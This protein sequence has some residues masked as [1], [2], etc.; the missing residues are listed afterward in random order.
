MDNEKAQQEK[1]ADLDI[2]YT[3]QFSGNVGE[4]VLKDL[5]KQCGWNSVCFEKDAR[6]EAFLLGRRSIYHYIL[7]RIT[8]KRSGK[9][10][11]RADNYLEEKNNTDTQLPESY[12]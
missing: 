6:F 1:D 4:A 12:I 2:C 11:E 7:S 9:A 8:R 5:E 3:S 10:E